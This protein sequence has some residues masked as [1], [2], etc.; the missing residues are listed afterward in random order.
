VGA[1]ALGLFVY[2]PVRSDPLVALLVQ[3]VVFPALVVSG[4][5]MWKGGRLRRWLRAR[6][7]T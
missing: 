1:V 5:L 6:R 2:A 4:L 3:A 7:G